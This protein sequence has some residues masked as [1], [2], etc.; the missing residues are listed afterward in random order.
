MR[1]N[2]GTLGS[3][4]HGT[5]RGEDLIPSFTHELRRLMGNTFEHGE[6]VA[7]VEENVKTVPNY[8][9]SEACVEDLE[10]L[11]D[12]LYEYAPPWCYFGS[13]EGDGS[14]YGFWVSMDLIEQAREEGDLADLADLG[15]IRRYVDETISGFQEHRDKNL[16]WHWVHAMLP[17]FAVSVNEST[18][19]L[20]QLDG[21]EYKVRWQW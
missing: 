13:H 1:K 15:S 5:M 17:E 10:S 21:R 4:S 8:W 2:E 6:L 12:A 16:L 11:F 19:I 7:S 3:I 9:E 14:D 18:C 20:Y